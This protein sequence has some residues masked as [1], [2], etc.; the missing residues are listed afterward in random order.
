[1]NSFLD[2]ARN[3]HSI[4]KY[5]AAPV[6]D[7]AI[8]RILEAGRLAPSGNNS[9]PWRFILIRDGA[10]KR[11]VAEVSGGQE[12]MI[13]APVLVAVIADITAKM[14]TKPVSGAPSAD[15]PAN[16]TLVIKAVRD[17]AIAADH[18]VLAAHDMGLGTCWVAMFEQNE[19]RPVLGVPENC[20]V[21]AVIS[22]G[23]PDEAPKERPRL[24]LSSIVF[25]ER[26]GRHFGCDSAIVSSCRRC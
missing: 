2:L 11:K 16:R 14:E 24:E 21:V 10:M 18:I 8:N 9:Q 23:T 1:M 4:R 12:W 6:G 19:I 20:Y 22:I 3:R 15:D 7:E 13:E 25:D 26:W 17:S 5:R